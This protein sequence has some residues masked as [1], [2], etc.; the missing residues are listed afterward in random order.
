MTRRLSRREFTR[1]SAGLAGAASLFSIV[2]A[3]VLG[4]AQHTAPSD[5]LA[6]KSVC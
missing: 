6:S 2:P 1:Q 5:K 4:G 3:H